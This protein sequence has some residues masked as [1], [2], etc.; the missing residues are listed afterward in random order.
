MIAI[1]R[2]DPD[3]VQN[4][5]PLWKLLF[6]SRSIQC[7]IEEPFLV[8]RL[9]VSI[10][11]NFSVPRGIMIDP[12][13]ISCLGHCV[14]SSVWLY[15]TVTVL[16]S[17]CTAVLCIHNMDT[18]WLT[19]RFKHLLKVLLYL[20]MTQLT[21]VASQSQ[22][23]TWWRERENNNGTTTGA[24][25]HCSTGSLGVTRVTPMS[26]RRKTPQKV[27]PCGDST[28]RRCPRTVRQSEWSYWV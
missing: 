21:Q 13:N 9:M 24:S 15:S 14:V 7:R 8:I 16:Y 3:S 4:I 10:S 22:G 18:V 6:S 27:R 5:E 11:R 2:W 1:R 26:T 20:I 23:I 28:I 17:D 19:A 25:W 12:C